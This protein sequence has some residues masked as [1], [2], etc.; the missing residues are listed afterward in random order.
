M[1]PVYRI[2]YLFDNVEENYSD[3][4]LSVEQ[5]L[6]KI[7]QFAPIATKKGWA[8][9][10]SVSEEGLKALQNHEHVTIQDPFLIVSGFKT[11]G[12]A[13]FICAIEVLRA[14]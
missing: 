5:A 11:P 2:N 14:Y 10:V 9:R 6:H 1:K 7:R 13:D 8:C 3:C 12:V 4:T